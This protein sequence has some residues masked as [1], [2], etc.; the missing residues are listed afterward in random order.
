[1]LRCNTLLVVSGKGRWYQMS[2]ILDVKMYHALSHQYKKS[3]V[4]NVAYFVALLDVS[5]KSFKASKAK[6]G[7]SY[8]FKT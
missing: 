4:S 8:I 7:T 6:N 2:Q 5:I 1:M 3:L